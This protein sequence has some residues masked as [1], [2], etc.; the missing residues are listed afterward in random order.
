MRLLWV[1]PEIS[2]SPRSGGVLRSHRLLCSLAQAH[3]VS[4]VAVGSVVDCEAVRVSTGAVDVACFPN[5]ASPLAKRA[6]AVARSWPLASSRVWNRTAAA[7]VED[8][9]AE[10]LGLV[11]DHLHSSIYRPASARAVLSLQ[12]VESE[13][14]ASLPAPSRSF[15]RAERRWEVRAL[16][17]LEQR[18]RSDE[19]VLRVTVSKADA[20]ALGG[21]CAVV[22]NGTDPVEQASPLAMGG[23]LL[24]VG[25]MHYEPNVL[26]V[27]W[28][29]EKVWPYARGLGLPPLDVVGRGTAPEPLGGVRFHGEVESVEPWLRASSVVVVPLQHGGGTRLKIL[30]AMAH[31]R[32]VVST[33]R[34]AE[35]LAV[36]AGRELL[37]EDDAGAFANA[38]SLAW[39]NR[40]LSESL[41]RHG[42]AFV[43]PLSWE[44]LGARFRDLVTT[45]LS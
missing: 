9:L 36:T 5:Q 3:E 19:C 4:V 33:S 6:V 28:W 12:N 45:H 42:Q 27:R 23:S 8:R 43:Q 34:G 39:S 37:V 24:F 11:L 32:P 44:R 20:E 16:G 21:A 10:G 35:G 25:S 38:V 14:L 40:R 18:A 7:F 31:R 13:V 22:P 1:T 2:A 15:R 41:T 29:S 26:G 17:R 30:E